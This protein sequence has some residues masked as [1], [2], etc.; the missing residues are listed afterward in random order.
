MAYVYIR[1]DLPPP[2]I[3][4]HR[5]DQY[6]DQLRAADQGDLKPSSDYLRLLAIDQINSINDLTKRILDGNIRRTHPNGGVT[7][8]GVYYPP[9]T[10]PS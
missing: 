2:I 9:G 8:N 3:P 5:K 10:E 4:A 1:N 7:N 6:I